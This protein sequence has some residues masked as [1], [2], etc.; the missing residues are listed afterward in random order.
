MNWKKSAFYYFVQ[1]MRNA[2]DREAVKLYRAYYAAWKKSF[3]KGRNSVSDA[4]PWINLPALDYLNTVL[5]PD[6][7]VFE[8][9]GGGSTLFFC[10]KVAQ[11]VT[12]EDHREWFATLTQ[13]I[14]ERG[15]Q[16]WTG[17]FVPAEIA[18]PDAALGP[19]NP[20][21]FRSGAKGLENLR[22]EN[23]AKS[24]HAYPEA[25]FDLVLVDG[26]ARPSCI[27]EC[28]PHVKPGGFLVVDNTERLYY[29]AAFAQ[30]LARDFEKVQE[31]LAP[32]LYT[33]DFTQTSIFRKKSI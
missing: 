15:Y 10:S 4:L 1:V 25:Y 8:Y 31:A 19:E 27:Q 32:V 3:K 28:M 2:K 7:K 22:F 30:L 14:S 24:I 11:V 16:H 12:V 21:A 33:P 6:F 13:T 23:Y 26:R 29:L 17:H 5:K 18:N 9:G 20:A